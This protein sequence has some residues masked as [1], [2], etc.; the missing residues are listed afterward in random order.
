MSVQVNLPEWPLERVRALAA[1][2]N[3]QVWP[4]GGVVRD[5]LLGRPIHDWDFAVERDAMGLAR[6]VAKTLRGA[7]Y[8]LDRERD[9][10]RVV[11]RREGPRM[12][13][14]F[15]ALRGPDLEADLRGRDF[16]LN[17]MAAGPDGRLIDPH[18]GLADL[19]ARLL[20]A[21]GET[22][23]DDDPLRMLRAVRL[24]AE[25]DLRLEARTAAWI[26][27]RASTLCR[28]S[29]ER[30]RD[31]FARILAAP[32]V[33]SHLHMLD[34]LGLL[35]GI[36]PEV[37]PL[38]EQAQS[39]PHRF[40]VWWHTLLVVDAAEGV[41]RTLAG[42]RSYL[43]YAD[44]PERAWDDLARAL[45]R[46]G[47]ALTNHL[48]MQLRG[49]RT[50]RVLFLLAA[51]CHD[52]GKPLTCTEDE[53]GH[54]HFYGHER[55]G[56]RMTAE[57]MRQLRFSRAEVERVRTVVQ[58]HLRPGHLSRLQGP[59]TRRAVY[60]FFRAT[61]SGGVE[62][63]LLSMADHLATW[64]PNLEPDRWARRLAVGETLLSHYFEQRQEAVAPIPL[65]AG[66]DLMAELG[67][68]EGPQVGRLLEAVREAQAAGEICTREEALALVRRLLA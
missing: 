49:G 65:I 2:R 4:V 15:A 16:T 10:G 38:K 34:E 59:V 50:R 68:K 53:E 48:Q 13:L 37:E 63:M 19:Q 30:V 3:V 66:R 46:F 23:F 44:A 22:T 24:V 27:R 54:L 40:D 14:D 56:A 6:A 32:A 61:G 1:E 39:P 64:G 47:P 62:V 36:V 29:P 42:K 41:V 52:L 21:I 35:T 26:I 20:R 45:R 5:A 43:D 25:L 51:L 33:A 17:G 58:A 7:F 8:P 28:A 57:R 67:L 9:T 60:R 31:E 12:E 11:L 18:G 55:V